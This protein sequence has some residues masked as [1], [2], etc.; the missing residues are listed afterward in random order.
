[1][2]KH[3][4]LIFILICPLLVFVGCK[5]YDGIT[6]NISEITTIY[7]RGFDEASQAIGSISVGKRETPY[8]ID[9]INE[10]LTDFSLIDINFNNELN[11]DEIQVSVFINGV[12]NLLTMYF[13]P[14]NHHYM[15]DLGYSL[16]HGSQISLQYQGFNL[17]FADV[18]ASFAVDSTQAISIATQYLEPQLKTFYQNN[19]FKGECYLKILTMQ[20]DDVGSLFWYF[21]AVSQNGDRLDIVISTADGSVIVD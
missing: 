19:Q 21:S 1:M 5:K 8:K 11:V 6:E 10:K 7:Y 17:T 4:A 13:N 12:E 14:L 3:F 20:D 16:S 2:K 9:G 18:T 15:A